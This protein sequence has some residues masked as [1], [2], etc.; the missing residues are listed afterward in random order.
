MKLFFLAGY[1]L[2]VAITFASCSSEA[3]NSIQN[4]ST[5]IVEN[6]IQPDIDRSLPQKSFT[7]I[8]QDQES[9]AGG[10]ELKPG[11]VQNR[12]DVLQQKEDSNSVKTVANGVY[13]GKEKIGGI[14]EALLDSRLE[15]IASKTNFDVVDAHFNDKTWNITKEK[16]GKVLNI[17]SIKRAAL[18][19]KP[20]EYIKISY[21]IVKPKV[22]AAQLKGNIRLIAKFSTRILD[23]SKSRVSNICLAA[24][25]LDYT[26]ILPGEEFSFNNTTGSKSKK[27]G[28]KDATIIVKTPKGPEHRKAPGGGVCQLSTTLYNAVLKCG[29]KVTERHEHSDEVHYVPKGKDATVTYNGPDFKFINNRSNPIMIRV[30][31]GK[32]TVSIYILERK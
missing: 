8:P 24:K 23:R 9:L 20:G 5:Q 30:Y 19:A 27:M 6:T 22:T 7:S 11:N 32:K 10:D 1:L 25:K 17:E 12:A 28:Y 16:N 3:G 13:L 15:Y 14:S 26:I 31:V 29:L 18:S 2:L 21:I 4:Y